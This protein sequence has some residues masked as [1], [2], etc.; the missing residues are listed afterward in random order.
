MGR[1][2]KDLIARMRFFAF[3]VLCLVH[4][5]VICNSQPDGLKIVDSLMRNFD[6]RV[7]PSIDGSIVEIGCKF[8]I[9]S[10]QFSGDDSRD[11]QVNLFLHLEWKDSRLDHPKMTQPLQLYDARLLHSIWKPEVYFPHAIEAN[12]HNVIVPNIMLTLRPG[13]QI[14]YVLRLGLTFPCKDRQSCSIELAALRNDLKLNWADEPVKL[15]RR[16]KMP[17]VETGP[18]KEE[19]PLGNYSCLAASLKFIETPQLLTSSGVKVN[20]SSCSMKVVIF[21][22]LFYLSAGPLTSMTHF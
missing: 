5:N 3:L 9:Q 18:C 2:V 14:V 11:I 19:T 17:I 21:F 13:G 10:V 4:H 1:V 6:V 8:T 15:G 7:P 16:V 20:H 22:F 12:F